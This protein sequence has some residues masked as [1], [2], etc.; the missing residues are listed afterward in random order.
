MNSPFLSF[1]T[2]NHRAQKPECFLIIPKFYTSPYW[3]NVGAGINYIVVSSQAAFS[4][5]CHP[6]IFRILTVPFWYTAS[7]KQMLITQY[8][9]R[10]H[11]PREENYESNAAYEAEEHEFLFK[12]NVHHCRHIIICIGCSRLGDGLVNRPDESYRLW[13]VVVCDLE[14][15]GMRRL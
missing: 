14:A 11:T 1:Q 12:W 4:Y 8:P 13:C 7:F 2:A 15:L 5:R 10:T 6:E 9:L 3:I